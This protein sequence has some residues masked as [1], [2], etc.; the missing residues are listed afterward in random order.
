MGSGQMGLLDPW[1]TESHSAFG[2]G[3]GTD[4]TWT[5]Y[6]DLGKLW[7]FDWHF[8][9]GIIANHLNKCHSQLGQDFRTTLSFLP[10]LLCPDS[11]DG[12]PPCTV[13]FWGSDLFMM[14]YYLAYR[15]LY[16][17]CHWLSTQLGAYPCEERLVKTL[18][19]DQNS[20]KKIPLESEVQ[21]NAFVCMQPTPSP[22]TLLSFTDLWVMAKQP[23]DWGVNAYRVLVE[24][25]YLLLET[26]ISETKEFQAQ[27]NSLLLLM[28]KIPAWRTK[29]SSPPEFVA[30][31]TIVIPERKCF[32]SANTGDYEGSCHWNN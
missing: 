14:Y 12:S 13:L 11:G 1:W 18:N 7:M 17:K 31:P 21:S 26:R 30:D 4:I 27:A 10:K 28:S 8:H 19:K 5:W 32:I 29:V 9:W 3:N 15:L 23:A 2:Q 24:Y 6:M 22:P 25:C 16:M 20:H